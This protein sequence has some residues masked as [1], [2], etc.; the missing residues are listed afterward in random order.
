MYP[1]RINRRS[2]TS[3][4][5]VVFCVAALALTTLTGLLL[6]AYPH[7]GGYAFTKVRPGHNSVTRA[8][9]NHVIVRSPDGEVRHA[10]PSHSSDWPDG[11]GEVLGTVGYVVNAS[12]TG[13]PKPSLIRWTLTVQHV[14]P[15]EAGPPAND[16]RAWNSIVVEAVSR[17]HP[18]P[19]LGSAPASLREGGTTGVT[20]RP[21]VF[22]SNAGYRLIHAPWWIG[23]CIATAAIVT[24]V[25]CAAR[26]RAFRRLAR[27]RCWRC[28]YDRAG[29]S[30]DSPCP[31]CGSMQPP[32]SD[33]RREGSR[34]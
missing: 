14:Q 32:T 26:I 19:E 31:E 34:A 23:M 30:F 2:I 21:L 24:Y 10:R 25:S 15:A 12:M 27:N 29:I 22:A 16:A 11:R 6:A 3:R 13:H 9:G 17:L 5:I 1:S 4:M 20:F 33:T 7:V 28:G 8:Q 18:F